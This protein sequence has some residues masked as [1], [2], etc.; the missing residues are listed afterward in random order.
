MKTI[1][2]FPVEMGRFELSLPVGA[3]VLSV[4]AQQGP[5]QM[6]V[7]LDPDIGRDTMRR[8]FEVFGTGHPIPPSAHTFIGTFQLAS[9]SLVFHLFE[10]SDATQQAPTP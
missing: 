10:T 2:K 1:W 6:W 5:P 7:L 3:E 8:A 9:G 4:Q